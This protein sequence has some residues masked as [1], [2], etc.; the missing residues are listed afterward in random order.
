MRESLKYF[1]F[2]KNLYEQN[3]R[4]K[5][6]KDSFIISNLPYL[7]QAIEKTRKAFIE[8]LSF[9]F[10]ESCAKRGIK[11]CG[12]GIEWKLSISEFML[13]LMLVER[14]NE[15][16]N[17]NIEKLE[18]CLF[19]GEKGCNLIL[20][21]LFCRNFFCEDLSRFLGKQ[22]LRNIQQA[23]EDETVLSFKLSDYITRN[24]LLKEG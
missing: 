9:S 17:F 14:R 19:L 13:N 21:P 8:N 15:T 23:M 2:F 24:Y 7:E 5:F 16:L 18:D 12:E 11:C 20:V 6:Q 1:N 22:K 4:S 10:C 3:L